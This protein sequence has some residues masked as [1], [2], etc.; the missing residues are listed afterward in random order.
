MDVKEMDRRA[1]T[2]DKSVKNLS[3]AIER[4]RE[5]YRAYEEAVTML[6]NSTH[7]KDLAFDELKRL[8]ALVKY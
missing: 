4:Y 8:L 5:P 1:K 3:E 6:K 7:E 2:F